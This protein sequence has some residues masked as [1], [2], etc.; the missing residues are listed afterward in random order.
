M[1]TATRNMIHELA[2]QLKANNSALKSAIKLANKHDKS[3]ASSL[4]DISE[5]NEDKIMR[6]YDLIVEE[7][8][9]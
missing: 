5:L 3:L 2:E 7:E 9:K 1:N 8:K 6:A 4:K